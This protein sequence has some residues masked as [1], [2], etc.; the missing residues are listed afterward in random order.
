MWPGPGCCVS[1]LPR[2]ATATISAPRTQIADFAHRTV[3]PD[4]GD[5]ANRS[6]DSAPLT[7]DWLRRCTSA[8]AHRVRAASEGSRA[9][10]RLKHQQSL[11][12]ACLQRPRHC[13]SPGHPPGI[14]C[15]LLY[16]IHSLCPVCDG[17]S[18]AC[19]VE[20]AHGVEAT[21]IT[22][23]FN[24]DTRTGRCTPEVMDPPKEATP[25]IRNA[26]DRRNVTRADPPYCIVFLCRL[27]A[28]TGHGHA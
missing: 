26:A 24:T 9:R 6:S 4:V 5:V 25:Q 3:I 15:M 19:L 28:D 16:L 18:D 2:T 20:W 10:M 1:A 17:P 14:T 12:Q 7:N 27:S 8:S 21:V 22:T 11:R 13:C 23:C